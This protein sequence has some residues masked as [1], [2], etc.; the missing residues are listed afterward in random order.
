MIDEVDAI[1]EDKIVEDNVA[2]D[3]L[4]DKRGEDEI[5]QK[6]EDN[7]IKDKKLEKIAGLISKLDQKDKD[8][9]ANL[10]ERK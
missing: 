5:S 9:I 2:E 6:A 4:V 3:K 10:L 7:D 1:N 8:K